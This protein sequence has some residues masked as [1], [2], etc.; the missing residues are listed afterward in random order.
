[1]GYYGGKL[2]WISCS[3][4]QNNQLELESVLEI[5]LFSD[6]CIHAGIGPNFCQWL[7]S[8]NKHRMVCY[9]SD[10]LD[11]V[12]KLN[13]NVWDYA[14]YNLIPTKLSDIF[15][16]YLTICNFFSA[17]IFNIYPRKGAILPG[18]DA[19]II[20]LNP[21][22]SFEI[23]AKSHHSRSDTNVYEGRRGKVI[24]V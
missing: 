14:F 2:Q 17:K 8:D 1:M 13:E 3:F 12:R 9:Y 19:D 11:N 22:S 4:L 21:N 6:L 7:C 20:I 16:S 23:T 10:Y 24:F 15:W 18:S 5:F